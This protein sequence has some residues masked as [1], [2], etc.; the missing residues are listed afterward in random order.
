MADSENTPGKNIY[1]IPL[2]TRYQAAWS[3]M[4]TKILARQ[5]SQN[6]YVITVATAL[7][8][9]VP[10][11]SR[12]DPKVARFFMSLLPSMLSMVFMV[13]YWALDNSIVMLAR[14]CSDYERLCEGQEAL[15]WFSAPDRIGK[16]HADRGI[17]TISY[18]FI[19]LVTIL[20][21][22][23]FASGEGFG[24]LPSILS[25]VVGLLFVAGACGF[26]GAAF[27]FRRR[28]FG[29]IKAADHA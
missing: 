26:S 29:Q 8:F 5:V 11:V 18:G 25:I 24:D 16:A 27:A 13:W 20:P 2:A 9:T 7:A 17:A 14:R 28:M 15:N 6:A 3:E 22:I 12:D 21:C 1:S 10:Y 4:D 19:S 23:V